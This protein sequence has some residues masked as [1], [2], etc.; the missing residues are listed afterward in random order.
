[1]NKRTGNDWIIEFHLQ[2]YRMRLKFNGRPNRKKEVIH[3]D[4]LFFGARD[5]TRTHTA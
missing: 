4:D 1:M 3:S 2:P 5:G